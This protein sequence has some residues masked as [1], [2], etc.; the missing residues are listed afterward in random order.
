MKYKFYL[1]AA[2]LAFET[3]QPLSLEQF[4]DLF[5]EPALPSKQSCHIR[6]HQVEILPYDESLNQK[7]SNPG[8]WYWED[9][10][11][12]Y[13]LY[14]GQTAE[15]MIMSSIN[16]NEIEVLIDNKYDRLIRP[17]FN[18]HLERLLLENNAVLM[19]SASIIYKKQAVL[20]TGPSGT[21]KTTH[22]NI[23]H[24]YIEGVEDLNGDRTLLQKTDEG[25]LACGFPISGGSMRCTNQAMKIRAIVILQQSKENR[26]VQLS[27]PQKVMHVF[28][29]LSVISAYDRDVKKA[30]DLAEDIAMNTE[31]IQLECNMDPEAAYLVKEFLFG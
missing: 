19:H 18:I 17:W 12:E 21:G 10:G 8:F 2:E 27:L 28:R 11:K 30:L 16:G 26:I 3:D 22:T 9:S 7:N 29:E 31:I 14:R 24:Q 6:V 23:W 15:P 25:W 4:D 1:G 13:R 20:F 5:S